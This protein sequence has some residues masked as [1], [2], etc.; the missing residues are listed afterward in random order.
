MDKLGS[1]EDISKM[2]EALMTDEKFAEVVTSIKESFSAKAEDSSSEEISPETTEADQNTSVSPISAIPEI[3]PELISKLP[4]IIS[5]MSGGNNGHPTKNNSHL[6]D[7]KHLLQALKPFLSS[8]RKE[9]V[10]SILNV[11]GIADLLGL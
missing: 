8:Q 11:A 6:S 2:I 10:D 7:R 5:M 4:E 9:A 3:S 1:G